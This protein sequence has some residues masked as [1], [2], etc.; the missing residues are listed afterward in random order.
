[1]RRLLTLSL[2]EFAAD[3]IEEQA[4]QYSVSPAEL[5]RQAARYYL[6]DLGSGR[7]ALRVPRLDKGG[8]GRCSMRLPI[9]LDRDSWRELEAEAKRQEVPIEALVVHAILYFLADLDSGRVGRRILEDE[10]G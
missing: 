9:D 8:A 4:A 3:A 2:D 6:S 1:M 5:G 10:I 7:L